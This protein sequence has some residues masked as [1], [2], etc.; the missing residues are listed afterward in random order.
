M[1][2]IKAF[3]SAAA[4][5][6]LL[7]ANPASTRAEPPTIASGEAPA[8][9]FARFAPRQNATTTRLDFAVFDEA[10]KFMVLSMYQST[11]EG[12]GRPAP[13][14]GTNLTYGHTSRYRLE[15]NRIVFSYLEPE[16]IAPLTEYRQD[17]EQIGTQI[18]IASLPR[19]EQLAYWLNLHNVA[20]IEQIAVN[21]PVRSP[22]RM[23]LGADKTPLDTTRFINVDGVAM[24]PRD[25][26]TKIVFPNWS[27]PNVI[28]GFFRGE[29]GGPSIQ[30]RAYTGD[31]VTELLTN[32][33]VEF[34]NSLR[35]IEA[36]GSNLLVSKIYEEA[37]PFYFPDMGADFRQHILV[38]ARED[39]AELVNRKPGVKFNAYEDD[40]ADLAGGKRE[41][42]YNEV[43]VDN[44]IN[45][46]SVQS[47]RVP[48]SVARTLGER[49]QKIEKL[50]R[51]GLLRGRVIV[52][53]QPGETE[54]TQETAPQ[55]PEN[56]DE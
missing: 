49:A 6:G 45:G 17:L 46:Q 35:G 33:A 36:F 32:S 34:V 40:V 10:L 14:L 41:P 12:L 4:A 2:S 52:L 1:P 5:T 18:D 20:V 19:N 27:D 53:P 43:V 9:D 56:E 44:G 7:A 15:G 30:R 51:E 3:F 50:R 47:F 13:G 55:S 8:S 24:S 54:Q 42:T 31:N 11:R 23:K 39:V 26:R 28:Y 21:Y 48:Q 38:H 37:A 16:Q 25:I 29:I 22:S